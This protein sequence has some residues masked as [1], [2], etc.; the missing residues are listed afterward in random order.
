MSRGRASRQPLPSRELVRVEQRT[1][2]R[3]QQ[4]APRKGTDGSPSAKKETT[5]RRERKRH[6]KQ[7]RD[8]AAG[9][10]RP[11]RC[12]VVTSGLGA[13][14]SAGTGGLRVALRGA[15]AWDVAFA[16]LLGVLAEIVRRGAF[17]AGTRAAA[18]AVALGLVALF[19]AGRTLFRVVK[20]ARRRIDAELSLR[21][22]DIEIAWRGG[23]AAR[24][25]IEAI[26]RVEV[27]TSGLVSLSGEVLV[28]GR[29]APATAVLTRHDGATLRVETT[30]HLAR[31][32][33]AAVEAAKGDLKGRRASQAKRRDGRE[34]PR[35]G[36][37]PAS[38]PPAAPPPNE[39]A[40]AILG[41]AGRPIAA[42]RE[43]L[44]AAFADTGYRRA[45]LLPPDELLHVVSDPRIP[46][47]RRVGAV[48]ALSERADD[49]LRER[50]RIASDGLENEALRVAA[51]RAAEGT[52]EEH[53]LEKA[54]AQEELRTSR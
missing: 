10:P 51:L 32:L 25:Q 47:E 4:R 44:R 15:S 11:L 31:Q 21:G 22:E 34:E 42:W 2:E 7:R 33:A 49:E 38:L 26:T 52:L 28:P 41:R 5:A 6:L 50:L 30:W 39:A 12:H 46:A 14:D 8:L 43:A 36:G 48:L 9:L 16:W 37:E 18:A 3:H 23:A 20:T 29:R 45:P 24:I 27:P 40:L 17:G 19:L 35:P 1:R 13:P 53:I 54:L